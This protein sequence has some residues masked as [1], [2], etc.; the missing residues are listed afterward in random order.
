MIFY[1][2]DLKIFRD[3]KTNMFLPIDFN[4]LKKSLKFVNK[5]LLKN[6]KKKFF[7]FK[8]KNFI[9]YLN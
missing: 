1:N 2:K 3:I 9:N 7:Y 4:N 6:N 5:E 8:N